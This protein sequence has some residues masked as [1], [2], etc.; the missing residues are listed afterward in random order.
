M[1]RNLLFRGFLLGVLLLA[2]PRILPAMP[3]N[4]L[5]TSVDQTTQNVLFS[6]QFSGVPQLHTASQFGQQQDSFQLYI[7]DRPYDNILSQPQPDGGARLRSVV[8]GGEIHLGGGLP[9]RNALPVASDNNLVSGGWGSI[10]AT[11]PFVQSGNTMSFIASL[12][13]LR[14]TGDLPFGLGFET[15]HFGATENFN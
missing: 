13:T 10:V 2:F 11:V 3:L 8:R 5:S 6:L 14:I 7:L 1:R 12:S 4:W 9:I 15:F